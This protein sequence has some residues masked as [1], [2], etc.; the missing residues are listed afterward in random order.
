MAISAFHKWDLKKKKKWWFQW[1]GEESSWN[2]NILG[3]FENFKT[4]NK[5]NYNI[6]S[7]E[8]KSLIVGVVVNTLG[9]DLHPVQGVLHERENYVTVLL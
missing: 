4:Q 9:L 2:L 5:Q 8:R 3:Q 6:C 1:V 7:L